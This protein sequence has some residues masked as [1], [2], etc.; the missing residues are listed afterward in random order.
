MSS[1]LYVGFQPVGGDA[2]VPESDVEVDDAEVHDDDDDD[3][4]FEVQSTENDDR[5]GDSVNVLCSTREN[6]DDSVTILSSA[7]HCEPDGQPEDVAVLSS[8][9]PSLARSV[10]TQ[11][12]KIIRQK[13]S[14]RVGR[15]CPFCGKFKNRLKRHIKSVHSSEEVVK[16]GLTAG[17]K[18]QRA[19]FT[20]LR[21]AGIMKHNIRI[22]G[23]KD[24]VLLRDRKSKSGC[25]PV[26]CDQ[27]SGVISQQYMSRH[28][29]TCCK[30][31]LVAATSVLPILD[32]VGTSCQQDIDSVGSAR[33]TSC[34]Q[35][36]D[37]IISARDTSCQQDIDSVGSARDTSCQQDI[38]SVGSACDTSCQQDIDS[39]TRD[40]SSQQD[41]DSVGSARDASC[42]QDTDT[43]C[44]QII[45]TSRHQDIYCVSSA[46]V[47][48]CHQDVDS[49]LH[50]RTAE[51]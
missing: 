5:R 36:I 3:K 17:P 23:Q 31:R 40:T 20:Q 19:V 8:M 2:P 35:D 48:S 4:E 24:A 39:G 41:T 26:V 42:Q 37:S 38:D 1:L 34:Q 9:E 25:S 29:K 46:R 28:R 51:G 32:C 15:P 45:D 13:R 14:D 43:L 21:R 7:H 10:A 16:Y 33:D 12:E 27:C 44:H 11:T 6:G 30:E 50:P 47:T 22:A 18:T 49:Q